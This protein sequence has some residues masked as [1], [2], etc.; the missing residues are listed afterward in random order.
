MDQREIVSTFT[1]S[2]MLNLLYPQKKY[3]TK[4]NLSRFKKAIW[5][6]KRSRLSRNLGTLEG[7]KG[8]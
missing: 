8:A 2:S 3:K 7:R 6:I 1:A 4:L 5:F